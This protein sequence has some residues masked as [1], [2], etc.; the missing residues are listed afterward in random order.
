M[1]N[2]LVIFCFLP[3]F[4]FAQKLV[5]VDSVD[6]AKDEYYFVNLCK[7]TSNDFLNSGFI[8]MAQAKS[9][10]DASCFLVLSA[11]TPKEEYK[12]YILKKSPSATEKDAAAFVPRHFFHISKW[13]GEYELSKMYD[14]WYYGFDSTVNYGG[15]PDRI[16]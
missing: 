4:L 12:F 6:I 16:F 2:L 9:I 3:S 1:K 14:A 13:K 8:K 10:K 5:Q 15:I 11:S 7:Q